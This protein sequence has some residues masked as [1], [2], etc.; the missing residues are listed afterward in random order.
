MSDTHTH[1]QTQTET[2]EKD[3]AR[4]R[5]RDT[6]TQGNTRLQITAQKGK[7]NYFRIIR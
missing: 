1:T 7:D 3:R 6:G 4:K 2:L 5:Q